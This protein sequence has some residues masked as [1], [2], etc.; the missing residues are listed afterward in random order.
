MVSFCANPECSEEY[1]YAGRG[2]IIV[3]ERKSN[4]ENGGTVRERELFWL[5]PNC[6]NVFNLISNNGNVR[7]VKANHSVMPQQYMART[8]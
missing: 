6:E 5:C 1:R 4:A 7:C 2:R 3:V 8:S